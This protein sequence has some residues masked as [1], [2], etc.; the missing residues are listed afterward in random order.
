MDPY[1]PYE[2]DITRLV[3]ERSNIV[4]VH[5]RDLPGEDDHEAIDQLEL[6]VNPGWEAYGGIIRDVW[7]ELRPSTYIDN[8]QFR[9]SLGPE[10]RAADCSVRFEIQSD[11]AESGKAQVTLSRANSLI[12]SASAVAGS[13]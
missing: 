13:P 1:V 6:G 12:A 4:S 7:I 11:T 5:L 9:Y 3:H 8:A 10:F 2:F